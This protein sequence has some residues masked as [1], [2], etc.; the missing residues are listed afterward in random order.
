MFYL[1][2]Y[3]WLLLV[4]LIVLFIPYFF[5]C[6]YSNPFA[7]DFV[8][9]QRGQS[10]D[11]IAQALREYF[12]WS[13][14]YTANVL[15]FLNPLAFHSFLGYKIFPAVLIFLTIF[16][17]FLLIHVLIGKKESP[18]KKIILTLL[19]VLLFLHQM[20]ILSEGIYWYAGAVVYQLGNICAILYISLLYLYTQKRLLLKNQFIHLALL[21]FF[22]IISIGF[23]EIIM[24]GL[25]LFSIASLVIVRRNKLQ[26]PNLFFYLF[27]ITLICSCI[28]FFAPGN[29]VRAT[30]AT[31]NHRF[32]YS[33]VMGTAQT[34]RF[35]LEW[36]SSIPLLVLSLLYYQLN[37]KLAA[38]IPLFGKSFYL[39][40]LH[41]NCI[42]FFVIFMA[43]FPPYWATGILGQHRTVNVAYYLFLLAWFINLTVL[44]NALKN[45]FSV[46][47]VQQRFYVL[48]M[49]IV[50]VAFIFTKNGYNVITDIFYGKASAYNQQMTQ[51][52]EQF[53]TNS[54]TIYF[55]AIKDPP[56]SLFLYDVAKEPQNWMNIAYTVYFN[57]EH[58]YVIRKD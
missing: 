28:T 9:G 16:S 25:L 57:C 51:R 3:K 44:F 22:L 49:S 37:E 24:L 34:I 11:V 7:D 6:V 48:L 32:I 30:F 53:Q 20:P 1:K 36:V 23:N 45:E 10:H 27:I 40:P 21:T 2:Q 39:K 43:V 26:N 55:Q 56:K 46:K 52:Y 12:N 18:I 31:S 14:R 13:G 47:L 15:Q 41:S 19:L 5:L 54:D 29:A 58:K 42:L 35:F 8:Y 38:N 4:C 50:L 17:N 33:I